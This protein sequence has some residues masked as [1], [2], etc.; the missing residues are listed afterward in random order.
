MGIFDRLFHRPPQHE[1]T[2]EDAMQRAALAHDEAAD[3][4]GDDVERARQSE[5]RLSRERLSQE[6]A[7]RRAAENMTAE[8]DPWD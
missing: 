5:D 7:D 2:G 6:E 8:G 1:A 3:A 4:F